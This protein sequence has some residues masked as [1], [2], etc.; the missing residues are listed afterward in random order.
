MTEQPPEFAERRH[1][2]PI[3]ASMQEKISYFEEHPEDVRPEDLNNFLLQLPGSGYRDQFEK[4]PLFKERRNKRSTDVLHSELWRNQTLE[5]FMDTIA[6]SLA[7]APINHTIV[8]PL[9][10]ARHSIPDQIT[11][12]NRILENKP[13]PVTENQLR[14]MQQ[15]LVNERNENPRKLREALIPLYLYLRQKGYTHY[16]LV[17]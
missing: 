9:L 15:E 17:G 2:P 8:D 16:D 7:E 3:E 10:E 11:R 13:D 5:E 6:Q 1:I 14:E 4:S 12:I